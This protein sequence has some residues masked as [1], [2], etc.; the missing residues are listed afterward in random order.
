VLT[1]EY[2]PRMAREWQLRNRVGDCDYL[3]V[4]QISQEAPQAFRVN[5]EGD[6]IPN[7]P[8]DPAINLRLANCYK[9]LE[10]A[11]ARR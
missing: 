5:F 3:R 2:D 6:L 9:T 4:V 8:F 11:S 10:D 1:K 7:E